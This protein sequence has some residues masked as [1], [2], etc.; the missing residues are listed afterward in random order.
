MNSFFEFFAG[1]DSVLSVLAAI[2]AV[3]LFGLRSHVRFEIALSPWRDP[4]LMGI[5]V[6]GRSR[7][8]NVDLCFRA[9][10][11]GGKLRLVPDACEEICRDVIRPVEPHRSVHLEAST[12][13]PEQ[14]LP[15]HLSHGPGIEVPD[16]DETHAEVE[17]E[18]QPAKSHRVHDPQ[19][20]THIDQ[21]G[22][23]HAFPRYE[24]QL[25][26]TAIEPASQKR[27][28]RRSPR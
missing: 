20:G 22:L 9:V 8:R 10:G 6:S 5:Y 13:L 24:F 7:A 27:S 18:D 15:A 28:K 19:Y 23:T 11:I 4:T 17:E 26:D 16:A 21:N 12:P 1:V 2:A 25:K 3:L 14:G